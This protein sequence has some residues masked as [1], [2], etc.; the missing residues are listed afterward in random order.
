[1]PIF[2][3]QCTECGR[4]FEE[5]VSSSEAKIACPNCGT[6][7]VN[8]KL[9]SF[10]CSGGTSSGGGCSAPAGSGFR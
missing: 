10:A 7:K 5:L 9:S 4:E 2:E 8:R 6:D 3:Y 1:M